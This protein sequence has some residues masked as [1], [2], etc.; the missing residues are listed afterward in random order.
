MTGRPIEDLPGFVHQLLYGTRDVLVE[1]AQ[2]IR[3]RMAEPGKTRGPGEK[4]DW[5]SP[6]QRGY[7]M[8]KLREGGQISYHRT[9]QYQAGWTIRKTEAGALL[10]NKH[11]A[12]AIGGTTSGW[13]SR[14]HRNRRPHLL[15]VLFEELAK[16]PAEISNKF[17]VT[18]NQ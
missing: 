3:A 11:P 18:G 12:G 2:R 16:I 5:D 10:S 7:V 8:A 4:V 17:R 15:T 9:G 1:T 13:Q 14:I 6:K